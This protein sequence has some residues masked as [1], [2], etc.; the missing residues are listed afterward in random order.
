MRRFFQTVRT[1]LDPR[2]AVSPTRR[3]RSAVS[4]GTNETAAS[5]SARCS[6][7]VRSI[8]VS[9]NREP[10]ATIWQR[11]ARRRRQGDRLLRQLEDVLLR[12]GPAQAPGVLRE[13]EHPDVVVQVEPE[14]VTEPGRRLVVVDE[15]AQ[16]D[17][18]EGAAGS[19]A[20]IRIARSHASRA[21]G[22]RPGPRRRALAGWRPRGGARRARPPSAHRPGT[23]AAPLG[24]LRGVGEGLGS[25]G[26][27]RGPS[28]GSRGPVGASPARP[29]WIASD[30]RSRS[31]A[32]SACDLDRLGHPAV[33]C[34]ARC[35][36]ATSSYSTSCTSECANLDRVDPLAVVVDQ[37]GDERGTER[38]AHVGVVL[39]ECRRQQVEPDREPEH[40]RGLRAPHGSGPATCRG[41][42]AARPAPS[43]APM[44]PPRC[45][46]TRRRVGPSRW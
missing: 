12:D 27:R 13:R 39:V 35:P 41:V 25:L 10:R 37:P 34:A 40:R 3:V 36:G 7:T 31:L 11:I 20:P 16:L 2:S 33:Q 17:G 29:Q 4:A 14:D 15:P 24:E 42:G 8:G 21:A 9:S 6:S 26:D 19:V 23:T 22:S 43:S 38:V 18:R 28:R 46:P 5:V 1:G 45:P 44:T 32:S 30:A